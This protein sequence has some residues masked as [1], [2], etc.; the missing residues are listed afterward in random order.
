[1]SMR[2]AKVWALTA[3]TAGALSQTGCQTKAETGAL[4][5]GAVGTAAGALIGGNVGSAAI[6]GG[7]GALTGAVVGSSMDRADKPTPQLKPLRA[8]TVEDW[9]MNNRVEK[10]NNLGP[11]TISAKDLNT[12][13]AA[14][15]NQRFSASGP[16]L[17]TL[18]LAYLY[19]VICYFQSTT[20]PMCQEPMDFDD[21]AEEN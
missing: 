3:I 5:G 8:K 17:S 9:V 10:L 20:N 19:G 11:Y 13:N 18:Q 14:Y 6:G 7:I 12:L 1:M 15:A 16:K 2:W 4:T 21:M